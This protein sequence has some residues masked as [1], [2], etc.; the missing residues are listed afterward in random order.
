LALTAL[1]AA[2][3]ASAPPPLPPAAADTS[4][5]NAPI[6]PLAT[7][8]WPQIVSVFPGLLVHGSGTFLQ[9][10]PRTT[11]RLLLLEGASLLAIAIGGF[12]IYQTGAAR[13]VAGAATLI[14]AAGVG[15]FGS[16][17][18]ASVYA[19][20]APS[21]GWG[22]P[23]R[24]LP[25]FVSG[26]GYTYVNDAQ[27]DN[28]HFMTAQVD[29][30][31]E[32]WHLG[33]DTTMTPSAGYQQLSGRAGY[34][35]LGP[36]ATRASAS[37]GSYLEPQVAYTSEQ[38]D[39]YGF[40]TRTLTAQLEGRLDVQRLLPDVRGGFF[41]AAIGL[42][43]QWIE[44]DVPGTHVTE[45]SGI[46]VLHSGFGVYIG[47]RSASTLAPAAALPGGELEL[48]YDHRRDGLVGG[49]KTLGPSSGFVG[50][51][52]LRGE[53]YL[54]SAWGLSALVERGSTWVFGSSVLFRT[55]LP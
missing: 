14:T 45:S 8:P 22:E 10:R 21:V 29:G 40:D 42:A 33:V 44:F 16:S 24:R 19:S 43:R 26:L 52:G 13:D 20:A 49:I 50:H 39:G 4:R 18:F 30:R 47:A 15:T 17:F 11:E 51:V 23:R 34:R 2:P 27:F 35:L 25:Q 6:P 31:I 3:P 54:S 28:H 5:A 12:V 41:Q 55:D 36:R 46:L 38:L 9:G 48:Y 37:D 32:G 1:G 7:P 53:Y